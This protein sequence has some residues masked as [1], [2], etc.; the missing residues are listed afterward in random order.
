MGWPRG[1]DP[2]LAGFIIFRVPAGW[3]LFLVLPAGAAATGFLQSALH[4]CAGFAMRGV[5]NFGAAVGTTET[6]EQ[7]EFRRKDKAKAL[8]IFGWSVLIGVGVAVIAFFA[9]W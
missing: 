8:Q 6:V 3:R 7:A 2:P 9:V 5:F 1:D 4:F